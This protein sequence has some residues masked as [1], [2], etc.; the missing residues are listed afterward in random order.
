MVSQS[1]YTRGDGQSLY[2]RGDGQSVTLYTW[3]W[4]E[5]KG[6]VGLT[7]HLDNWH[8][9]KQIKASDEHITQTRDTDKSRS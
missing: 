2:T 9:Y 3:R 4:S 1:L 7:A 5:S 8:R 6:G